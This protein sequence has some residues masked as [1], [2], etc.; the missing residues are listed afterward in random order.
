MIEDAGAGMVMM[1]GVQSNQFPHA[2][3]SARSLCWNAALQVALGGFHVSG[4]MSMLGGTYP[5]LHRAKAMGISLFA[6]EAEGRLGTVLQ[7]AFASKLK[8]IYNFMADLPNIDGRTAAP[9]SRDP[10]CAHGGRR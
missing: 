3:D 10:R 9:Y 1:V 5:D 2:L 8:P 4:T 7:D 6:G